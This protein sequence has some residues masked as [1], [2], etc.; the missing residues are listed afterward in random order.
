MSC[1]CCTPRNPPRSKEPSQS[2]GGK[3]PQTRTPTPPKGK[4]VALRPIASRPPPVVPP[5]A[6]NSPPSAPQ[7]GSSRNLAHG[8]PSRPSHGSAL[9]NPYSVIPPESAQQFTTRADLPS[10][11]T[12]QPLP[13]LTFTDQSYPSQ[14]RELQ[15]LSLS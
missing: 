7:V 11:F 10:Q 15:D 4:P 13:E 9:F 12:Q 5:I 6:P 1:D 14:D 2:S 8:H 3:S